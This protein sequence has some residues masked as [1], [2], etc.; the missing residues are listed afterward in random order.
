MS[1]TAVRDI[2]VFVTSLI[3]GLVI[4][5]LTTRNVDTRQ[6]VWPV[7]FYLFILLMG[8]ARK[9]AESRSVF[10]KREQFLATFAVWFFLVFVLGIALFACGR[11]GC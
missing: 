2:L 10:S 3:V 6:P 5:W 8:P 11:H 4:A 9:Y 1:N 7:R